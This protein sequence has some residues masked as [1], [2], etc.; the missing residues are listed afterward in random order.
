MVWSGYGDGVHFLQLENFAKVFVA[1]RS[2]AHFLLSSVREF[3]KN[4]AVHIA[5]MG[6]A[7]GAL[8]GFERGEVSVATAIE[9]D[10]GKVETTIGN[11][12]LGITFCGATHGQP[13]SAYCKCIEKFTS[14][15]HFPLTAG[16]DAVSPFTMGAVYI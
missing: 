12:D 10:D 8:V 3:P 16:V 6:D 9:T 5:D 14:C 13:C 2:F 7:G 1:C 15:N 4:V 11:D